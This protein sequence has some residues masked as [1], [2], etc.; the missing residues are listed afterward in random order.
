MSDSDNFKARLVESIKRDERMNSHVI[1]AA[2]REALEVPAEWS[3]F[4]AVRAVNQDCEQ[5]KA[6]ALA[7]EAKYPPNW[8]AAHEYW[9]KR[10][11]KAESDARSFVARVY[12]NVARDLR[13]AYHRGGATTPEAF[14]AGLEAIADGMEAELAATNSQAKPVGDSFA[15]HSDINGGAHG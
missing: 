5:W 14:A 12:R 13:H 15:A 2:I 3:T 9:R 4:A 8:Q 7:A 1:I 11:E 6:R 10:A